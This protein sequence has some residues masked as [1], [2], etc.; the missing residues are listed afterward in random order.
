[1]PK[2]LS[3]RRTLHGGRV[4]AWGLLMG[5]AAV[6]SSH[7]VVAAEPDSRPVI[8]QLQWYPQAQFAGYLMA[9]EKGFFRE[10]GV[11]EVELRW[12]RAGDEPLGQLMAGKVDFC[13]AWLSTAMV[14]RAQGAP[15]VHLAQIVR[16]STMLLVA[17]RDA[18]IRQPQDMNGR[19]VG[20]WGGDF[21]L[22][23]LAFFRKY[24]V[25]P[26]IVPQTTSVV[27]F[28]RRAVA[29]ASAMQYNEYHKLLESG[30]REDELVVF[31]LADYGFD[32]PEDGLYATEATRRE[33]GELCAAMVTAVHRGW[34]YALSHEDE[35]LDVVMAACQRA[36]RATTRSHQR[37]ML[38]ALAPVLALP[39]P[40]AG[41]K[42][43]RWG[44]LSPETYAAVAAVLQEQGLLDAVPAFDQ[45]CQ[46]P[47]TVAA[48]AI[49]PAH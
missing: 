8:V 33:R 13:T 40:A 34:D 41:E 36:H 24:D 32:V 11:P 42:P 27:P 9:R 22:L 28:L 45:F 6:V 23:P 21:D 30:L 20:L 4:W 37:W 25:H 31:R 12:S 16:Q 48:D 19:R 47:E 26:E 3:Q 39:A 18:E 38:Q 10:A 17:R 44:Q 43:V 7:A 46:P 5:L 15:L 49:S 14:A 2:G 1:M 29:V 35:T